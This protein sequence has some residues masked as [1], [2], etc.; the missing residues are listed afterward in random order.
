M[1]HTRT[2]AALAVV[3]LFPIAGQAQDAPARNGLDSVQFAPSLAVDLPRASQLPSGGLVRD[4]AP[5]RGELAAKSGSLVSLRLRAW[6]P[7]GTA[8]ATGPTDTL[9]FRLGAGIALPAFE[10]AV[11]GLRVGARRQVVLPSRVAYGELGGQDI[12]PN[13]PLVFDVT[14][15]AVK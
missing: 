12:P 7:N 3:V 6:L 2:A 11:A 8:L 1:A 10:D 9:T 4:L 14:V 5:G 13:S 15:L